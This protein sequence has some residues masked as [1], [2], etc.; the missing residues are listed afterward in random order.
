MKS[1]EGTNDNGTEAFSRLELLAVCGAVGLLALI[2]FPALAGLTHDS[3]RAV[4]ANNLRLIGRGIHVWSGDH[5]ERVPWRTRISAGGTQ[6]E[7]GD[8]KPGH[9]WVEY[10]FLSNQ[11][12]TPKILACPSD[13]GVLRAPDFSQFTKTAYREKAVSYTI[14]LDFVPDDGLGWLSS[15]R[16]L[17]DT[18]AFSGCSARVVNVSGILVNSIAGTSTAAWNPGIVHGEMGHLLLNNGTVMF[19]DSPTV[20]TIIAREGFDD[21]G[22]GHFLR[23]R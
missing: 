16:N 13:A 22:A 18:G 17:R 12:V 6:P 9:A 19:I 8:S 2:A 20:R 21:N 14:S 4:C 15:D 3:E 11:L 5:E 1:R 23:A 10:Y 7:V